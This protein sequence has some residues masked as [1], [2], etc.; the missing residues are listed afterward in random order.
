MQVPPPPSERRWSTVTTS[1]AATP[2]PGEDTGLLAE[3]SALMARGG[4]LS[5]PEA[6]RAKELMALLKGTAKPKPPA[7]DGSSVEVGVALVGLAQ[8][9]SSAAEAAPPP[10]EAAAA[11][12]AATEAAREPADGSAPEAAMAAAATGRKP[13]EGAASAAAGGGLS[14]RN[15]R[16]SAAAATGVHGVFRKQS[17]GEAA[18]G[19][20]DPLDKADEDA[21]TAEKAEKAVA[22]VKAKAKPVVKESAATIAAREKAKKSAEI[23]EMLR[24]ETLDVRTRHTRSLFRAI[25]AVQWHGLTTL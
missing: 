16:K 7:E 11:P 4:S 18:G 5:G 24:L 15:I 23:T 13:V 22:R 9:K 20:S 17:S 21:A 25:F 8:P 12:E 1:E 2:L 19:G 6:V 14:L 10:G 3:L